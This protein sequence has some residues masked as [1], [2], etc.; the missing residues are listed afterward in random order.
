MNN[1]YL[2]I[3]LIVI[4]VI[5][6]IYILQDRI[7]IILF[8]WYMQKVKIGNMSIYSTESGK[9][10]FNVHR[11]DE[12]KA[13]LNVDNYSKFCKSV[14]YKSD[15]GLCQCYMNNEWRTPDLSECFKFW[16]SND[17]YLQKKQFATNKKSDKENI[18]GHY[19]GCNEF[20]M[21]ILSD[22]FNAYTCGF[23]FNENDTLNDSQ[24]NKIHEI[25]RKLNLSSGLKVLDLGCGW[26]K[27]AEYIKATENVQVDCCTISEEHGNMIQERDTVFVYI[28]NYIEI[29]R[30]VYCTYDR[31]YSIGM[32]EH[33]RYE[34]YDTYFKKANN[35]LKDNGR[36]LVHTITYSSS[37]YIP[38]PK[39]TVQSN[40]FIH[41]Y[42]FPGGQIPQ[43]R[44]VEDAAARNGFKLV[45]E[46]VYG[47]Q[48]YGKTLINWT[49]NLLNNKEYFMTELKYKESF[50]KLYEFYFVACSILFY[51]DRMNL[52]QFVFEKCET[53]ENV[54][55]TFHNS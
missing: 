16:I 19:E 38:D 49:I 15:I 27:I 6:T 7:Y 13:I 34:N 24:H 54:D 9:L 10:L 12:Y 30:S 18:K 53:L 31:I 14:V 51:L 41:E 33:I 5:S 2:V 17:I 28:M 4:V 32:F 29:P 25:T 55:S 44:W 3:I 35:L 37:Y 20:Y 45:H 11:T 47:G 21:K 8:E 22:D 36:F 52:T 42:I 48:H 43:R 40:S 46:E 1:I 39:S 23:F 50:I 26:G